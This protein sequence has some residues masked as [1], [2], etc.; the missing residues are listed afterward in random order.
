MRGIRVG[1]RLICLILALA[2]AL[3]LW[4]RPS[5]ALMSLEDERKMGRQALAEVL[6]SIPLVEDPD[7]V[8]YVRGLGR[9]LEAFVPDKPFPFHFYVADVG[10]MNAFAIPGGYIFMFRGMITMVE[11]EGELAGVMAHEMGHVWRRHMARRLEKSAPVNAA[12]LA[13]M[14]AG[15][16]LGA[17]VGAPQLGQAVTMG[18]IAGGIQKQLAFSREDEREA[19]WAGFKVMTAA[20]YPP[21]EMEKSF[22]RIWRLERT[23]GGDTPT[24][25]RTHPTGPQRMEALANLVRHYGAQKGSFSNHEFLRVQTRLIAL[26][27]PEEEAKATLNRRRVENPQDPFPLYGLALW[28]QRRHNYSIAL[29]FFRR[30]NQVWPNDPYLLRDEGTCRLDMGQYP[31]ARDLL[32]RSLEIRPKDPA[33]LLALGRAYQKQGQLAPAEET[34]R[35][36]LAQEPQSHQSLYE[37][38]VTLGRLGRVGEASL[39]LGLAFQQRG[40]LR[41]ARYHL[42]RAV[43]MLSGQPDL[44]QKAQKALDQV[45]DRNRHKTKKEQERRES[46]DSQPPR[47]PWNAGGSGLYVDRVPATPGRP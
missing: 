23:L 31:Q 36:L 32:R 34:F 16:V 26:Y 1:K 33:A 27:D 4:P 12:T 7:I 44:Q 47:Q 17:A 40:R 6:A 15:L 14:L 22:Q 30:L 37:L 21:E 2:L 8:N 35:R 11:S 13:G 3:S 42:S 5:S 25:L 18:S 45:E 10:E 29:E 24:Y 38:G 19:D 46:E 28:N 39:Y 20:G 9:R 41:S 43:S